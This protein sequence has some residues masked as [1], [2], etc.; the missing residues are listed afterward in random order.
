[1]SILEGYPQMENALRGS[2]TFDIDDGISIH[3]YCRV[4]SSQIPSNVIF[5]VMQSQEN[6]LQQTRFVEWGDVSPDRSYGPGDCYCR[7]T[8]LSPDT[9]K[10]DIEIC[11]ERTGTYVRRLV[12][13]EKE[14]EALRLEHETVF[15]KYERARVLQDPDW[16]PQLTE[17]LQSIER[18]VSETL[19]AI[20]VEKLGENP[21]VCGS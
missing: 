18:S 2:Y 14:L 6:Y 4:L 8:G 17:H 15:Q 5:E 13:L 19:R 1:M 10:V 20:A 21:I 7:I 9:R 3:T 16:L 12:T 11:Y